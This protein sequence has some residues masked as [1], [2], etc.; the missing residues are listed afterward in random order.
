MDRLP[1]TP[2]EFIKIDQTLV[3]QIATDTRAEAVVTGITDI[4]RR[5]GA[6]C[7]AEGVEDPAQLVLLRQMGC[8]MAQGFHFA[9]ALPAAE[10]ERL[11]AASEGPAPAPARR[12]SEGRPAAALPPGGP[13]G[14]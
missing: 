12:S 2:F 10:L 11:V 4:A 3:S 9:P 5:L 6:S 8:H 14:H 13:T 7:I 1:S